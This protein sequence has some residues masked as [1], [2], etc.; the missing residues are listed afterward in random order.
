MMGSM[1]GRR[2]GKMLC[3]AAISFLLGA[4][5]GTTSSGN[6]AAMLYAASTGDNTL[7]AFPL[8]DNGTLGTPIG[9]YSTGG[10]PQSVAADPSNRYLFS[11][12]QGSSTLSSFAI[13]DNGALRKI[14]D[15]GTG[16][17]S[18]PMAVV[19]H[20]LGNFV[21]AVSE[22]T[23]QVRGFRLDN[24]T[25]VSVTQA[26]TGSLPAEATF[27]PNGQYLYVSN[28]DL[29][30]P[31]LSAFTVN[32]ANGTL[33]PISGYPKS[34]SSLS[35]PKGLAV[36]K[37]PGG[38][39]LYAANEYSGPPSELSC[40]RI[41]AN[42][43]LTQLTPV[44]ILPSVPL[45]TRP[46]ALRVDPANRLLFV[47]SE[48]L[49][50]IAAY[51]IG[52]GGTLTAALKDPVNP[53]SNTYYEPQGELLNPE[54]AVVDP[55]GKYLYVVDSKADIPGSGLG[56]V[57]AYSINTDNTITYLGNAGGTPLANPFS[58]VV[59]RRQ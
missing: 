21:Y 11:A 49:G 43:T 51:N 34:F 47:L 2:L 30:N 14:G 46:D 56:D 35:N 48:G 39:F 10:Y 42:G 37:R 32:S 8:N 57:Y 26:A 44:P 59:I 24:G 25:L 20:P 3:I 15:Y 38:N 19:V 28:S 55:N 9:T 29:Y 31:S 18:T 5:G 41:N 13:E 50:F 33:Q 4:C 16:T 45:N 1:A 58:A 6:P 53:N 40:F 36:A 7:V 22:G 17:G 27:D 23:E 52:D 12:N 54:W